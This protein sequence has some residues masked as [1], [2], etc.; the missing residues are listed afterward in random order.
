MVDH[1]RL[2]QKEFEAELK[3]ELEKTAERWVEEEFARRMESVGVDGAE[4]QK[5]VRHEADRWL[6]WNLEQR[7]R[8][9][10]GTASPDDGVGNLAV[11][12]PGSPRW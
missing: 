8:G 6:N 10:D 4:V 11:S 12:N 7:A 5:Q 1:E 9:N 2:E 3:L